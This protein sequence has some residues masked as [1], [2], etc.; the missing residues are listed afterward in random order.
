MYACFRNIP[1][2]IRQQ[3]FAAIVNAGY[4]TD[5]QW[6]GSVSCAGTIEGRL[7]CPMGA[8]NYVLQEKLP[9]HIR[10]GE[11]VFSIKSKGCV[12]NILMPGYGAVEREL[13]AAAGIKVDSKE[14]TNFMVAN[15]RYRFNTPEKLARAMGATYHQSEG[16]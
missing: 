6:D 13:L 12:I 4:F 1:K 10:L 5:M 14:V 8:V 2:N 16:A 9:E 7:A 11:H 3:A 15:D